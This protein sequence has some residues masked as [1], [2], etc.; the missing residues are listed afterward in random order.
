[1]LE[2]KIHTVSREWITTKRSNAAWIFEFYYRTGNGLNPTHW[3]GPHGV[4]ASINI[5]CGDLLILVVGTFSSFCWCEGPCQRSRGICLMAP[6]SEKS[7]LDQPPLDFCCSINP[8]LIIR[9]DCSCIC[10]SKGIFFLGGPN[11]V[12]CDY[13]HFKQWVCSVQPWPPAF[14]P[15]TM[16][17]HHSHCWDRPLMI[18]PST[19]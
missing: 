5:S 11:F 1:M 9:T 19:N 17:G 14:Q 15:Q 7:L 4:N 18:A 6:L 16:S 3:L 13:R 10:S 8:L 2:D 12:D